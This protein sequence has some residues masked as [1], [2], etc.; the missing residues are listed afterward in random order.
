MKS[1]VKQ[2]EEYKMILEI[3][4]PVEEMELAIKL[5]SKKIS[6]KVNIPGFRKGKAPQSVIE[7]FVGLQAILEEATD[8]LIPRCYADAIKEHELEPVELPEIN[9]TQIEKGK[10]L[11]FTATFTVRPEVELGQYKELPITRKK[12]QV[13]DAN[14][15]LEINRMRSMVAKLIDLPEGTPLEMG[16]VAHFDFTGFL[17]GEAFE[18]G[19]ANNYSLEIGSQTFIPGFEEQMVGM[20]Q[21]EEK[22]INVTFPEQYQE[23]KLAGQP[24]MFRIKINSIQRKELP[25]LDDAFVKEISETCENVEQLREEVR[26]RLQKRFD[27]SMDESCRTM[28]IEKAMGNVKVDIPPLMV[29]NRL[30][31]IYEDMET[32]LQEQGM[33]MED[34]CKYND[35]TEEQV[36]L[37][38]LPR[39]QKGVLMELT[40]EA[41]ADAEKL[42]VTPTDLQGYVDSLAQSYGQPVEVVL[43]AIQ[44]SGQINDMI[45]SLK[46]AKA[47]EFIYDAA[48]ITEEEFAPPCHAPGE[49]VNND[50]PAEEATSK[51]KPQ[52]AAAKK[53]VKEV[54][55]E[56]KEKVKK[57]TKKAAATEPAKEDAKK[58]V[59]DKVKKESKKTAKETKKE[60]E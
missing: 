59:K 18:G 60:F 13:T 51:A 2:G 24:V 26:E 39:A 54:D 4:V 1:Q 12:Y 20:C 14:I 35:Q 23:E 47:A 33:S 8:D 30:N 37:Q 44:K 11:N 5:A 53:E 57:T 48:V 52:K 50:E 17:N 34:Y 31:E 42:E 27:E 49:E 46:N 3:E 38:I 43:A 7:S 25:E 21:G 10:P 40:L 56:A 55:K 29:Q 45:R 9:I 16:D 32:R 22:E 41:I 28:V 15:D 58:E 36:R 6:N 19:Q